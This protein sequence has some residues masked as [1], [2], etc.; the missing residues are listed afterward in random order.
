MAKRI[1]TLIPMAK[2]WA[3]VED[4]MK[5]SRK[6]AKQPRDFVKQ[7]VKNLVGV[8]LVAETQKLIDSI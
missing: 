5:F 7:G 8:S 4:S 3:L 2:S 6:E 1:L